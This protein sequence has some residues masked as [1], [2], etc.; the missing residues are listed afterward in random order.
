VLVPSLLFGVWLS[1]ATIMQAVGDCPPTD[2]QSLAQDPT[3][4]AAFDQAWTDSLEGAADEHE[5]G[6]WI[7][8]C[9]GVDAA[10]PAAWVTIV[11]HWASGNLDSV[12]L[13][14]LSTDPDC[15]LVGM[16]HTHP[17]PPRGAPG[18]DGYS[19][20]VPSDMDVDI[21]NMF[22]VPSFIIYGQGADPAGTTIRSYGP[23]E[24]YLP[25]TPNPD[26]GPPPG[27]GSGDDGGTGGGGDDGGGGTSGGGDDGGG[28]TG[29]GGTGDGGTPGGGSGAGGPAPGTGSSHGD[30]H[31]ITFDGTHLDFQASGEFVLVQ[32][33]D[34]AL[35]VQARQEVPF[36]SSHVT[37]NTAIAVRIDGATVEVAEERLLVDGEE[38]D[39]LDALDGIPIPGGGRVEGG[40]GSWVLTWADG[41]RLRFLGRLVVIEL[42][43]GYEGSVEGLL[44]NYDGDPANDFVDADGNALLADGA[45]TFDETYARLAPAW[46][47]DDETSLFTY[48]EGESP[49]TF[50]RDEVPG[51]GLYVDM[52]PDDIREEAE[53][54]CA[55]AGVDDPQRLVDCALDVG[56]TGDETFAEEA[57][58][59]E[60]L[61]ADGDGDLDGDEPPLIDA[62]GQGDDDEVRRL[63]DEGEDVDGEDVDGRTALAW[64]TFA[65][66]ADIVTDLLAAGAD[67]DHQAAD[68][69]TAL[70][71]AATFDL[72]EI[73]E[74]LVEAGADTSL[75]D[76]SGRTARDVAE[77]QGNTEIVELLG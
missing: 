63:L 47:V 37:V 22:G 58:A 64:A 60:D 51:F 36:T 66:R 74:L 68:G 1:L 11:E 61:L 49:A 56:S 45:L 24:P 46:R 43:A 26:Y 30:P 18:N 7:Y 40:P 59:L 16:F 53:A 35:Q 6:G 29:D 34:G 70:H 55:D 67:P 48:E 54:T 33:T 73:A 65:G 32:S 14:P 42:A 31:L 2:A 10:D 15:A 38:L 76:D 71:V 25:C 21:A 19:N 44:G 28:G 13:S 23:P 39:V 75:E 69:E 9:Q 52:L 4:A 3:V 72:R 50:A 17:G 20:D 41:T 12:A 57:A 62:A 27:S 5:E 8:R 77:S